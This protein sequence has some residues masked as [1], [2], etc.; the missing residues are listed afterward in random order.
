MAIIDSKTIQGI[1]ESKVP[2]EELMKK[3]KRMD[4][5]NLPKGEQFLVASSVRRRVFVLT[6]Y[7]NKQNLS[8]KVLDSNSFQAIDLIPL[9]V[10]DRN[11]GK[12]FG[13]VNTKLVGDRFLICLFD[14]AAY[15]GHFAPGYVMI[16]HT[17]DKSVKY[18]AIGSDP[19]LGICY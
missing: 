1:D 15:F 18:V 7:K 8:V 14:G 9:G 3:T 2:I 16:V 10:G 12:F 5:P 17:V 4:I 13:Y 19:A 11:L 6:D